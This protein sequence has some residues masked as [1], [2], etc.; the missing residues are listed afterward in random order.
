MERIEKSRQKYQERLLKVQRLR[1]L[2]GLGVFAL[3]VVSQIAPG[4]YLEL[5]ALFVLLPLFIFNF[6]KSR[7]I[8]RFIGSLNQLH[9]FY[10]KQKNLRMGVYGP[11]VPPEEMYN[12]DLA[13]DLDLGIFYSAVNLCFSKEAEK[14]LDQWLCQSFGTS[15]QAVRRSHLA[16]LLQ[17]PG[18]LRRMQIQK[19]AGKVD[20]GAMEKE[21]HRP[22][23]PTAMQWK[24][25]IPGAWFTLVVLL[26]TPIPP[27]ALKIVLFLYASFVLGYLKQTQF[28]FARLQNLQT[29]FSSLEKFSKSLEAI[30]NVVSFA[31]TLKQK[32]VTRS[33]Q[34]MGTLISLMSLR[35]NPILFY[36]LNLLL[37]WDF[38]LAELAE[39][40][41]AQFAKDFTPWSQEIVEIDCLGCFVNL[42][43]YQN[44]AWPTIDKSSVLKVA[45]LSHP[46][47][48][49][50]TVVTN[51]FDMGTKGV[52]II[53]GSNM[54]GK[55]TFLRALGLNLCLAN[56]GAPVFAK[57][58]QYQERKI[59]TCIRVSDS[60]RDGKSYFYAEVQRMK[61]I[62]L[63][64]EKE[65]V[66][67]L[68]DEPLRGTNN[69]E[70]LIGNQSYVDRILTSQ[71][72]GFLSTH[73]LELTQL[74]EH[75]AKVENYHFSEIWQKGD[76]YFDYKIKP[77]PSQ[78][79]NALKIL[80]KEGLYSEN[81]I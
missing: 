10:S 64:A 33:V 34:R 5:I 3:L 81:Q 40:T 4:F 39:R 77:G 51:S 73:D 62:L 49:Q 43:V 21:V 72:C 25:I 37:P 50:N 6:K 45:D 22:F 58:F 74:A 42:K 60:L 79:T 18:L 9:D 27:I 56:I 28:L 78:S 57:S 70:R 68:I 46:L 41:R 52:V 66:L 29:D 15:Q 67:F 13:R 47:L 2:L 65:P 44:T 8:S 7:N 48:N 1:L 59:M 80:A 76:L 14:R 54:S 32:S 63:A 11:G 38:I 53:T 24:W 23:L 31:P 69:R 55:S 35:T 12:P 16:E 19:A 61:S 26:F 71:G 30:S 17:V 20:F 36:I 75:A